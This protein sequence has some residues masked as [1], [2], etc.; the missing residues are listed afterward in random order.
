M[1]EIVIRWIDGYK[2]TLHCKEVRF[3]IGLL[4]CKLDSGANRHIPLGQV[5]WFS[6]DPD[7]KERSG[8]I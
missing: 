7:S 2:E 6:T 4:W 3:G 1:I 8:G 5:R